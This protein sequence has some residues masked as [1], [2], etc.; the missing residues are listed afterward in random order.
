MGNREQNYDHAKGGDILK[1]RLT[2]MELTG[3][4]RRGEACVPAGNTVILADLSDIDTD[5]NVPKKLLCAVDIPPETGED[6]PESSLNCVVASVGKALYALDEDGGVRII[7]E[8]DGEVYCA[9]ASTGGLVVMTSRGARCYVTGR[10]AGNGRIIFHRKEW[11]RTGGLVLEPEACA[12]VTSRVESRRL[13]KS[14]LSES[15]LERKDATLLADDLEAAYNGAVAAAAETGAFVGPVL[16]RIK[17][18]DGEGRKIGESAPTLLVYPRESSFDGIH[19]VDSS[20]SQTVNAYNLVLKTWRMKVRRAIAGDSGNP[21]NQEYSECSENSGIPSVERAEIWVSPQILPYTPGAEGTAIL[22]MRHDTHFARVTLPGISAGLSTSDTLL[23]SS[24][25]G[26]CIAHLGSMERLAA[27]ISRP[28]GEGLGEEG[29]MTLAVGGMGDAVRES[30]VIQKALAG[31]ADSSD[32]ADEPFEYVARTGLRVASTVF[33]GNLTRL[34]RRTVGVTGFGAAFDSTAWRGYVRI[35]YADGSVSVTEE[36]GLAETASHP[37]LFGPMLY[38]ASADAREVEICVESGGKRCKGVYPLRAMGAVGSMYIAPGN[39]PFAL[40]E[41]TEEYAVPEAK[42]IET[43]MPETVAVADVA[44]PAGMRLP[45]TAQGT[46][47]RIMTPS[48]TDSAWDFGCHK[49]VALTGAGIYGLRRSGDGKKLAV[50]KISGL[51]AD[52][53]PMFSAISPRGIY[54]VGGGKVWLLAGSRLSPVT[55]VPFEEV[56]NIVYDRSL[57]ALEIWCAGRRAVCLLGADGLKIREYYLR[58]GHLEPGESGAVAD[59]RGTVYWL[60]TSGRVYCCGKTVFPEQQ[61]VK[62]SLRYGV[63]RPGFNSPGS[64]DMLRGRFWILRLPVSG[65][66]CV[67]VLK[68]SRTSAGAPAGGAMQSEMRFSGHLRGLPARCFMSAGCDGFIIEFEARVGADFS[69]IPSLMAMEQG[70]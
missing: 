4:R 2:K 36:S 68:I 35:S 54:V 65:N 39:L 22:S 5:G 62:I 21:G 1:A 49:A 67:G 20:D 9:V 48:R 44:S 30:T 24:R 58:A 19:N 27:V 8:S 10:D 3:L 70:E 55:D 52:S 41:T 61:D 69:F 14:Y 43:Y 32:G 46:V 29:I 7:D 56:D 15:A 63:E 45:V 31:N 33:W 57:D 13:S 17:Y 37:R 53:G 64:I 18:F 28:F 11:G 50:S 34:R 6:S 47:R 23:A 60:E 51:T 66:G 26:A 25:L 40:E 59:F 16:A 12:A 42:Y 38:V